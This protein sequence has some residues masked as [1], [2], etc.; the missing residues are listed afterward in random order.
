VD[1]GERG[2]LDDALPHIV[3]DGDAQLAGAVR[4][5]AADRHRLVVVGE[6]VA[7][8]GDRVEPLVMSRSPSWIWHRRP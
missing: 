5:A 6:L 8:D 3:V 7:L 4:V 2:A 1:P